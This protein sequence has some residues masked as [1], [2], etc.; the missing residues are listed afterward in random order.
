MLIPTAVIIPN[1]M[2][3]IPPIIGSG[4]EAKITPNL[5]IR[6]I[7]IIRMALQNITRRDP[8]WGGKKGKIVQSGKGGKLYFDNHFVFSTILLKRES[9][10]SKSD[11]LFRFCKI[12]LRNTIFI[13]GRMLVFCLFSCSGYSQPPQIIAHEAQFICSLDPL[14]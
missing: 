7:P 6:P 11:L 2:R 3:Y 5:P 9:F 12:G 13:F 14:A 4:M 1:M 8:T 10:L